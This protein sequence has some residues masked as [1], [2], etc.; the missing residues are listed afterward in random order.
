MIVQHIGEG[1]EMLAGVE[2]HCPIIKL[3]HGMMI[4]ELVL[5]RACVHS[6]G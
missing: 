4:W 6:G 1:E 3:L 5:F 2:D